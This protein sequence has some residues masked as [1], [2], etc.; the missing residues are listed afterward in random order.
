[1][2]NAADFQGDR[3]RRWMLENKWRKDVLRFADLSM[4]LSTAEPRS[5]AKRDLMHEWSEAA[6]AL[7]TRAADLELRLERK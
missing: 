2:V 6:R 3:S 5:D 7:Y 1:M 4:A